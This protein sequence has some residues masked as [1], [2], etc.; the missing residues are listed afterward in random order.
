MY[1]KSHICIHEPY[2]YISHIYIPYIYM[3]HICI[4]QSYTYEYA[5]N[6]HAYIHMC[7]PNIYIYIYMYPHARLSRALLKT[8]TFKPC[9]VAP[10]TPELDGTGK[11]K[12]QIFLFFLGCV[13]VFV[14]LG[15][16]SESSALFRYGASE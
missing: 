15:C 12:F 5:V 10:L 16:S 2:I 7:S 14:R 4:H 9:Q 1:Q 3:S 6:N 8:H 13:C 11:T